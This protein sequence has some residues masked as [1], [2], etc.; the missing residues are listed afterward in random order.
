MTAPLS[1]AQER[2]IDCIEAELRRASAVLSQATAILSGCVE[3]STAHQLPEDDAPVWHQSIELMKADVEIMQ[4]IGAIE[5][6]RQDR[7]RR[8]LVA[9]HQN[10]RRDLAKSGKI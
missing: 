5:M 10:I 1:E 7:R 9:M 3:I 8:P 2:A 6:Q 4:S